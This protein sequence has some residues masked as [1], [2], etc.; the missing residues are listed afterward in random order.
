ML[1]R[2]VSQSRYYERRWQDD[3]TEVIFQWQNAARFGQNTVE[4]F[5]FQVRAT[6]TTGVINIVYGNMTTIAAST[7]YQPVVGLRGSA[8]TDYNNRRLTGTVPDA[9]P[10]W[11]APNGTTAGT[12]NAHTVRFTANAT[13]YPTSGLTFIWTP[14]SCVGPTL[15]IIT[16]T[17][18]TSATL[19]W[20]APASPPS[21]GYYWEIRTS[22]AGGSGATGLTSSGTT[23]AGVVSTTVTGLNP[24][25][26][27]TLY[28]SSNC[29]ASIS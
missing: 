20:T 21:S 6:K 23:G 24:Q 9:T 27:Y 22:G 4:R 10:N 14:Q 25:T 29:G 17:S 26:S 8:N 18:P 5:S 19:S 7:T 16:Y 13:C 28:V 2:S 11:G 1:F 3:G 12:S 15:P